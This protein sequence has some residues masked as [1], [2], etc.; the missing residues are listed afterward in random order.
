MDNE[1]KLFGV[2]MRAWMALLIVST[3]CVM[4]GLRIPVEEPLKSA[5][6]IAIGFYFGQKV[7][8]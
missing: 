1:S 6:L 3:V 5:L 4:S 2:S 8:S 7:K